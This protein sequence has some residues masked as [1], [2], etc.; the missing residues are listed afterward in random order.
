MTYIYIYIY[1]YKLRVLLLSC[2]LAVFML[3][4][5]VLETYF[6]NNNVVLVA[7]LQI[8][9]S[10]YRARVRRGVRPFSGGG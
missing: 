6:Q 8:W 5:L 3:N 9:Q 1:L 4:L 2:C 10:H 7:I